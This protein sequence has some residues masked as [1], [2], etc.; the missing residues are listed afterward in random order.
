MMTSGLTPLE[1]ELLSYVD[2]LT[3]ASEHSAQALSALE[4][5]S[6]GRIEQRLDSL[7][8][9]TMRLVR[10]QDALAR[11]LIAWLQE[12]ASYA[13]L[14]A[15]LQRSRQELSATTPRRNNPW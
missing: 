3:Q 13:E 14:E 8:D 11:S 10:S 9:C 2:A 12:S 15:S 6:T 5:R 1:R 7:E 4:R